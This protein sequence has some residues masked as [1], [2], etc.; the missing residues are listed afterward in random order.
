MFLATTIQ[1]KPQIL[2]VLHSNEV[3]ILSLRLVVALFY[4]SNLG[5]MY[6]LIRNLV[7]ICNERTKCSILY[8]VRFF[9][10]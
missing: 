4:N 5:P 7:G 2:H 10:N 9:Y 3:F 6:A 8:I 1:V